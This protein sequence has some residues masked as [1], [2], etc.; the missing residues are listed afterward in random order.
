M[1][2]L[3]AHPI[4]LN[5]AQELQDRK[6]RQKFFLA[7]SSAKIAAQLVALRK[8]RG[9]SQKEVAQVTGTQQ[10]AISR[11]EQADYQNWS[12]NT[13]RKTAEALDARLQ[14]L[15]EPAEDV[16]G[17]YETATLDAAP[18]YS[19]TAAPVYDDAAMAA[20]GAGCLIN[21][22]LD[23]Y[24]AGAAGTSVVM[25]GLNTSIYNP[26]MVWV[27]PR[28]SVWLGNTTLERVESKSVNEAVSIRHRLAEK[29][30]ILGEK[31]REITALKQKVSDLAAKFLLQCVPQNAELEA[32]Q[33]MQIMP[34]SVNVQSWR[35]RI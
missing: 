12:F 31:N 2:N 25:H 5:L 21:F 27:S 19:I 16:L 4:D 6:F 28:N 10:P 29:D 34:P 35:A 13:L 11:S 24:L 33:E 23:D 20:N 26:G 8:R 18:N 15:I 32:M 1:S 17:E 9:L 3:S 7:E 14:V 22:G 30:R